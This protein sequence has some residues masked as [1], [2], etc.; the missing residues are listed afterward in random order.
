MTTNI[1]RA[2]GQAI[3]LAPLAGIAVDRHR[4]KEQAGAAS[5]IFNMMRSLGGAIGTAALATII[6]KREQFHSNIIGQSVT[7]Y[8]MTVEKFLS[9]MQDY[10]LAHGA[11]DIAAA[12]HQAEILLGKMVGQQS[13]IMAFSDTFYVLGVLIVAAG[14][15]LLDAP[16]T[17]CLNQSQL[18]GFRTARRARLARARMS[19]DIMSST[20][21]PSA[22][23]A[24]A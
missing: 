3:V 4:A 20:E 1:V 21:M 2:I 11:G 5:G 6:T 23:A 18:A 10:F 12:R 16:A 22:S 9:D 19:S 14:A 8:G 7:P 15:V 24:S 13:L 17:G